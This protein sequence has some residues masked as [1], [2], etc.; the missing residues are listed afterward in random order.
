MYFDKPT[1]ETVETTAPRN[2]PMTLGLT[3]AVVF[4]VLLGVF[5]ARWTSLLYP[6]VTQ[7]TLR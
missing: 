5:P 1:A 6:A 3:L 4:T 7:L 2:V